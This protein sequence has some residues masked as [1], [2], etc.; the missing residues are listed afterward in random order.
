MLLY[1]LF[2]YEGPIDSNSKA[3]CQPESVANINTEEYNLLVSLV[4]TDATP[5]AAKN[6]VKINGE[7][8]LPEKQ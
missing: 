4:P 3:T 5:K 1:T 6:T 8:K 7:V 2:R